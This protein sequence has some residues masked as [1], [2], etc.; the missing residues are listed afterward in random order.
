MTMHNM[1]STIL[2][3]DDERYGDTVAFADLEALEAAFTGMWEMDEAEYRALVDTPET[4]SGIYEAG[5]VQ[6]ST[7][8]GAIYAA[9]G[10]YYHVYEFENGI[11]EVENAQPPR[12]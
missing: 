4:E 8:A 11:A 1:P 2:I 7:E 5:Y 10:R 6:A 12:R 9:N 3:A